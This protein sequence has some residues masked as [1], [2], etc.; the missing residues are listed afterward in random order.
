MRQIIG[1]PPKN[2]D[3]HWLFVRSAYLLYQAVSY[4]RRHNLM[5]GDN[6]SAAL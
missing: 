4:S 1:I 5:K 2:V 3:W 6:N